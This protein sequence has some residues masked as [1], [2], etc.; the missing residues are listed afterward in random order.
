MS[1]ADHADEALLAELRRVAALADPVP[2][3]P[4]DRA[5]PPPRPAEARTGTNRP[6]PG[7]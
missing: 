2:P 7:A 6:A 4:H 3:C 1:A 5:V